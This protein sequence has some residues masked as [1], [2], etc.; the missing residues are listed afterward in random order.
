MQ[1]KGFMI[2]ALVAV[3]AAPALATNVVPEQVLHL[4]SIF[5]GQ[6]E[7][8]DEV[9]ED[10]TFFDAYAFQGRAGQL[11]DVVMAAQFDTYLILM[12]PDGDF[13]ASDDDSGGDTNSR[14]VYLLPE[15]GSYTILA[16]SYDVATGT[17]SLKLNEASLEALGYE[18]FVA[19]ELAVVSIQPVIVQGPGGIG[20]SQ[21][22]AAEVL[23]QIQLTGEIFTQCGIEIHLAGAP[24]VTQLPGAEDGIFIAETG[25]S[26]DE[27]VVLTSSA[28]RPVEDRVVTA[29]FVGEFEGTDLLGI[30]YPPEDA[31]RRTAFLVADDTV[32]TTAFPHELGHV[33]GLPHHP[34]GINLMHATTPTPRLLDAEQCTT[35]RSDPFFVNNLSGRPLVADAA[36]RI[37]AVLAGTSVGTDEVL[38][39]D[40]T[41]L[42]DVP[43]IV[44]GD[45]LSGILDGVDDQL[46]DGTF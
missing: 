30:A 29:F 23:E 27:E 8:G 41:A 42:V 9:Y 31:G 35:M 13:L 20:G 40:L 25:F 46:E 39:P 5:V 10:G 33:L 2:I 19:P 1:R 32:G 36:S 17:Y 12:G 45:K 38:L 28:R 14:L 43:V 21:L 15:D 7:V 3:L 6:L 26:A 18:P 44:L 11:I 34:D 16:N 22:S 37:D 24:V 4:G